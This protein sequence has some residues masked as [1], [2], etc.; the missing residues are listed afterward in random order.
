MNDSKKQNPRQWKTW[1]DAGAVADVYGPVRDEEQ[2]EIKINYNFLEKLETELFFKFQKIIKTN[3]DYLLDANRQNINENYLRPPALKNN[4]PSYDWLSTR[5]LRS[6][7]GD[8][9]LDKRTQ[10]INPPIDRPK[11]DDSEIDRPRYLNNPLIESSP[12]TRP[13]YSEIDTKPKR[14]DSLIDLIVKSNPLEINVNKRYEISRNKPIQEP[15]S[16]LMAVDSGDV[17]PLSSGESEDSYN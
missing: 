1:K 9:F 7:K 2:P 5:C 10:N 6:I 15:A 14:N 12:R 16:Y 17:I 4:N 8:D 3:L 13:N 11:R